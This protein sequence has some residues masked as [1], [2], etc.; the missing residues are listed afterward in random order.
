[1]MICG[2]LR[3]EINS[4]YYVHLSQHGVYIDDGYPDGASFA[5]GGGG[6]SAAAG[7]HVGRG[8]PLLLDPPR[9]AH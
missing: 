5:I 8:L 1:M 6:R 9:A 2:F 7:V 4:L 3:K